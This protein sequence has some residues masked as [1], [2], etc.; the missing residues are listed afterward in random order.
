MGHAGP[1]PEETCSWD[2][3][4]TGWERHLLATLPLQQL[5]V[6]VADPLLLGPVMPFALSVQPLW[7]TWL[8]FLLNWLCVSKAQIIHVG[9]A[10]AGWKQASASD[11]KLR[12]VMT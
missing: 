8:S 10:A 9:R 3:S 12:Y 11:W 7:A 4:V 5:H 2:H 1:S 6:T